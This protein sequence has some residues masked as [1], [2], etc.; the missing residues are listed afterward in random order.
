MTTDT[1][2]GSVLLSLERRMRKLEDSAAIHDLLNHYARSID[3]CRWDE[4]ERCF[5][6]DCHADYPFGKHDGR[7]GL[8]AW[9]AHHLTT[10]RVF[11][12]LFGNFQIEL[13]SDRATARTNAS[14]ACVIDEARPHEHFDNGGS[15]DWE[16]R[17]TAE[18]WR[19]SRVKL[20]VVWLSREATTANPYS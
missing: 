12:H 14:I 7:D 20:T 3:G 11:V 19:V 9:C 8:G 17:R 6:E 18:G 5:T 16:L 15:Y 4:W 10:F 1:G 2:D 13:D